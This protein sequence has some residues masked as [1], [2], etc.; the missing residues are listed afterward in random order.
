MIMLLLGLIDIII[1]IVAVLLSFGIHLNALAYIAGAYLVL[2]G[3]LFLKS[4]ASVID[5]VA[6][7][8]LLLGILFAFPPWVFWVI[9]AYLVQKG[10]FSL[11]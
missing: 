3:M 6:G 7:I 8:L 4:F 1:A 9:A 5:M 10:I 2:K 11:F